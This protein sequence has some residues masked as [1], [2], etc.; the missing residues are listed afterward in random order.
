MQ[1]RV[2]G[3]SGQYDLTW[4]VHTPL[5]AR[6]RSLP[7]GTA[8]ASD[9]AEELPG[10]VWRF[11][12]AAAVV[13]GDPWAGGSARFAFLGRLRIQGRRRALDVDFHLPL[14]SVADGVAVLLA[15]G[16]D[17]GRTV[18]GTAPAEPGRH[19]GEG[20]ITLDL[21]LAPQGVPMFNGI[22]PAG[23][24]LAPALLTPREA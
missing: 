14:L 9:A 5:L 17:S 15:N 20:P 24:R 6:I 2:L 18:I 8:E 16:R 21:T 4:G 1:P 3:P 12:G 7:D 11:R 13:E 10:D 19:R 22:Y 23:T